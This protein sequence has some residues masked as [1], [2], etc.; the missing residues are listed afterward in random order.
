MYAQWFAKEKLA[1]E[2]QLSA[3]AFFGDGDARAISLALRA[4]YLFE[5][6]EKSSSVLSRRRAAEACGWRSP[7][8][9]ATVAAQ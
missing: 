9:E 8:A 7:S 5:G 6:S 3:T 4:T 2:P 1:I